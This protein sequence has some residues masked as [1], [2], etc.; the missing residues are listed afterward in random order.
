MLKETQARQIS[1]ALQRDFSRVSARTAAEICA[2]AE[3]R[4]TS[5]PHH[6]AASEAERL[7]KAINSVKIMSPPTNCLSAIGEEQ[8]TAGL[9]KEIGASFFTAL[10]R[11]PA[12][13]RGNP[14]QIEVGMAYGGGLPAEELVDLLRFANRVPLQYQQ[15]AC[16]ITKAVL[17]IDWR[18][19][20]LSQS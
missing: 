7:Y 8:I 2:A 9:H 14:F 16:A 6:I 17:S 11:S 5:N 1:V 10:T 12:V 20:G 18:S 4:P 19:Y 15:S 3:L 13:Y